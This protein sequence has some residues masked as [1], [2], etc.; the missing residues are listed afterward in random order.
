[1]HSIFFNDSVELEGMS[2]G[3]HL[4]ALIGLTLLLV[5]GGELIIGLN[6]VGK[7]LG[8]DLR[9]FLSWPNAAAVL[10][11][12]AALQATAIVA[13]VYR[14]GFLARPF[15]NLLPVAGHRRGANGTVRTDTASGISEFDHLFQA[16][17]G[18][19]SEAAAH[20]GALQQEGNLTT[21]L[22]DGLP[23]L[24]L[25]IDERHRFVRWNENLST[26]TGIA[27]A[28]LRELDALDVVVGADRDGARAKIDE[29]FSRGVATY[30][31][32]VRAKDGEVRL[33]QFNGRK[34]TIKGLP[35]LLVV[36]T[37]VTER[38]RAQEALEEKVVLLNS[39]INASPDFIIVK[40]TNLRTI[41][42][43]E[44]IAR[45]I[46][47][48]PED[49]YGK[50]DIENGW[51]YEQVK[52]NPSKAIRGF[53]ADDLDALAG[54][55]IRNSSDPANVG[56][57]VH[58]FDTFKVPLRNANGAITGVL[59][60]SRDVTDRNRAE[61]ALR[62]S[63]SM[64]QISAAVI[65]NAAEGVMVTDAMLQIQSVNPAFERITGYSGAEVVG[66]TPRMLFSGRHDDSFFQSMHEI[67]DAKGHWHG[68]IWNRRHSGEPYPQETSINVLRDVDGRISH[69]AS[70]FSDSTARNQMEAKLRELSSVDGLTG[71]AN[72]RTFDEVLAREW[73]RA[74]RDGL[75]LSLV[76]TDIDHFKLYNDSYGH[77]TGDD[78]LQRVA[79]AINRCANRSSDLV[80][81]YG[82]EEFAAVLPDA[83]ATTGATL[84]EKM[85]ASVAA[86]ALP[87]GTSETAAFVT[88][89]VGVATMIPRWTAH[90]SDLVAA[91]DRALYQAKDSGRNRV[92]SEI[93]F[94]G[95]RH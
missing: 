12:L 59:G 19:A 62:R 24:F 27:D 68:E 44:T 94:S 1:M 15:H 72:R 67:V 49:L 20:D 88:I 84:A 56:S 31:G 93:S 34:I 61:D 42:C 3:A 39:I 46:G 37:D 65:E 26:I 85:R 17:D 92:V 16:I 4:F 8:D 89:S 10:A 53:E 71:I 30:E 6:K 66:C 28:Q 5:A 45:A 50:T 7:P 75:P 91:A 32:S 80:A 14:R 87:H 54:I 70:V 51:P 43:N 55:T 86:L 21:A 48:Q 9:P 2:L 11:V 76:M 40:D 13:L 82:G 29:G 81:R 83:A 77:V 69:Y 79:S 73:A 22:I 33:M 36:G 25:L 90:A 78:C 60:I 58:Y 95:T 64:L 23:G 52:G 35:Y 63:N 41:L 47:K 18:R 57:D 74:L 38:K